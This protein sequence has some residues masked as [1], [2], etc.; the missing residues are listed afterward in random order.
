MA[1]AS[2][3]QGQLEI[4]LASTPGEVDACEEVI[5]LGFGRVMRLGLESEVDERRVLTTL[6]CLETRSKRIVAT[7]RLVSL[8]YLGRSEALVKEYRIG[9]GPPQVGGR[10]PAPFSKR[11]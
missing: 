6:Y 1:V 2:P 10:S 5:R 9:S 7:S 8:D 4:G 3:D 11:W